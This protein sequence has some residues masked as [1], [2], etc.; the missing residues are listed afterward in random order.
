[1]KS[2]YMYKM[3]I[4][5]FFLAASCNVPK[6]SRDSFESVKS[7]VLKVG[8]VN[9]PPFSSFEQ[10]PKGSEVLMIRDFSNQ[11]NVE[12]QFIKGSESDLVKKLEQA[13]IHVL[14]GG[15]EKNTIWKEKSGQTIPYDG[16][17][18]WLIPKGENKLLFKLEEFIQFAKN[19]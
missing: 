2:I 16:E 10:E 12:I 11:E 19:K 4:I 7:D 15:F 6:D 5:V 9:N 18:V 17:H 13:D 3:S 14:L 8:V 1:M